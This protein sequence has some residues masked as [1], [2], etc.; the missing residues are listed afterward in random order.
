MGCNCTQNSAF[1]VQESERWAGSLEVNDTLNQ[2]VWGPFVD[3]EEATIQ[4]LKL[5]HL[6]DLDRITGNV[7]DLERIIW[8]EITIE[9][10]SG[11]KIKK[12][13]DNLQA[14]VD[15]LRACLKREQQKREA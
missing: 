4:I 8:E 2:M 10:E 14:L 7:E 15:S 11:A 6:A 1:K 12:M 3:E 9:S 5:E 13:C